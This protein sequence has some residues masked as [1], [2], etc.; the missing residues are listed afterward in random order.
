[1]LKE[2]ASICRSFLWK[3]QE[4]SCAPGAVA[5]KQL[6]KARAAGG[7]GI[8]DIEAWNRAAIFKHFWAV[9][10]KKDNLWVRWVHHLYMKKGNPWEQ[11]ATSMSSA[12]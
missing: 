4:D 11:E 7:L 12:Y 2:I 3:G 5:W 8:R 10:E 9:Q 1:M 6:C